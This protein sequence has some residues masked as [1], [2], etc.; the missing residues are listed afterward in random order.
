[1]RFTLVPKERQKAAVQFLAENAFATPR[2]L[3]RPDVL[4]RMEPSG[5]LGRIRTAQM[6]VL[7]TLLSP[8]RIGR[9]VEQ[10]SMES[11]L[12]YRPEKFLGDVRTAV[13][14]ELRSASPNVDAYRRNLQRGYVELLAARLNQRG[15]SDDTRPLFRGEL[16][17]LSEEIAAALPKMDKRETLLHFEDLR[18]QIGMALDPRFQTASGLVQ[19]T[20]GFTAFDAG[21]AGNCWPDYSIRAE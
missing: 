10:E 5:E 21:A 13:F 3:I 18:D 17:L 16:K 2:M 4:R 19:T 7:T 12:A 15:V 9:L 1:V 6:G 20:S 11:A 14:Q 8:Q